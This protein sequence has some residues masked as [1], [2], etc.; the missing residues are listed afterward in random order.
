MLTNKWEIGT[1]EGAVVRQMVDDL[2]ANVRDKEPIET[3]V[4]HASIIARSSR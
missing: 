2:G 1:G 3:F 4:L